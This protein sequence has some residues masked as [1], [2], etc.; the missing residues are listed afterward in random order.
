MLEFDRLK[1]IVASAEDDV[2]KADRGNKAA[3]TR[4][5]KTMQEIK[6]AAQEVRIKCLELK[7]EP[8]APAAPAEPPAAPPVEPLA[9]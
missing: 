1:E 8:A 7:S 2:A 3:G 5:R 4:V 9:E 6:A